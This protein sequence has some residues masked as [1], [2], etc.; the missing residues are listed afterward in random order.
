MQPGGMDLSLACLPIEAV[1]GQQMLS[2][3]KV[4]ANFRPAA[5]PRGMGGV[6][7]A[8]GRK[9][10]CKVFDAECAVERLAISCSNGRLLPAPH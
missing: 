7:A 9:P 6:D 10:Y 4:A 5:A 3:G 1:L 8:E 2:L